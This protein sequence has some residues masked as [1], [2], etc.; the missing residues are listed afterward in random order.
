MHNV[1]RES[2]RQGPGRRF[3]FDRVRNAKAFAEARRKKGYHVTV[4]GRTCWVSFGKKKTYAVR[5]IVDGG[6]DALNY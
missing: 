6:V 1:Y 5:E 4:Y 2:E 3:W